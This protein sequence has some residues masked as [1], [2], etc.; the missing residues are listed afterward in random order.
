MD[1]NEKQNEKIS[2]K[3]ERK[4]SGHDLEKRRQKRIK[5]REDR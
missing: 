3:S 1:E 5:W 2:L 4:K